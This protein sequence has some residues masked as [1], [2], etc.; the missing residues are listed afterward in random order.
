MISKNITLSDV[1][2]VLFKKLSD[3][4]NIPI[5]II[6]LER[7]KERVEHFNNIIKI[8]PN[9]KKF[10]AIDGNT[11]EIE[12]LLEKYSI[13]ISEDYKKVTRG[14]LGCTLSHISLWKWMIENNIEKSIILEDDVV[15]PLDFFLQMKEIIL[16]LPNDFDFMYLFV[17][18]DKFK[19]ISKTS[20]NEYEINKNKI[21]KSYPT[22][23]TVG[24][25]LTL[26]CAK[27]LLNDFKILKTSIDSQLTTIL[28]TKY[29]TFSVKNIFL[30][31]GGQLV[32]NKQFGMKSN[33]W[34]TPQFEINNFIKN[35]LL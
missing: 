31:T 21:I 35:N 7:D 32:S 24:Y 3:I 13:I 15:I 26:N 2:K 1:K 29:Q 27:K 30:S 34:N 4:S 18:P 11:K 17:H 33:I 16:E 19:I 9:A 10:S 12:K 23:G 28:H 6:L 22:W 5:R 25:M 20:N 8:V 14:Q